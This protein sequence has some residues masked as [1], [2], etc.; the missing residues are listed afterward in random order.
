MEF[1]LGG[2]LESLK[3]SRSKG[4]KK[5]KTKVSAAV[6]REVRPFRSTGDVLAYGV[7]RLWVA[8]DQL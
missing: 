5:G 7:E 4:A 1:L 6:G 3:P 2:W 8:G